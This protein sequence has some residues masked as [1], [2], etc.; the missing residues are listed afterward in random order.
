MPSLSRYSVVSIAVLLGLVFGGLTCTS[1]EDADVG[2]T[3]DGRLRLGSLAASD[4]LT[5]AVAPGDRTLVLESFKGSVRLSGTDASTA[6]LSLV[7]RGFGSNVESANDAVNGIDVTEEGTA[8]EY[9]YTITSATPALSQ[10]DVRGVIPA[11]TPFRVEKTAGNVR[12][13]GL[14]GPLTVRQENGNVF[15]R[16]AT[17]DVEV[18]IQNGDLDVQLGRLPDD[19]R[20]ALRTS[21]GDVTLHLPADASAQVDA[22]T[23]AGGVRVQGLSFD[24]Q[25]LSPRSAGTRYAGQLGAGS[26]RVTVDTENGSITLRATPDSALVA[27]PPPPDTTSVASPSDASSDT[28][29]DTTATDTTV[30]D[31][32]AA[33]TTASDTTAADTTPSDEADTSSGEPAAPDTTTSPAPDTSGTETTDPAMPDPSDASPSSDTT[34]TDT[35]SIEQ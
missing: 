8:D 14:R 7:R 18:S 24:Q 35:S 33:D 13:T 1:T 15:V 25:S 5:R 19:A 4:S 3:N 12:L 30:A 23:Q 17:G 27:A 20:V 9:R 6:Q 29:S 34:A 10:A 32:T 28:S 22:E 16:G 31:T 2:Q 26:A 21:N 11:Q